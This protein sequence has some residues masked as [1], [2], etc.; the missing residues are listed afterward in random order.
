MKDERERIEQKENLNC[1]AIV[2]RHSVDPQ[3]KSLAGPLRCFSLRHGG[4][5]DHQAS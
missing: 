2:T 1:N 3:F 4:Q 5:T